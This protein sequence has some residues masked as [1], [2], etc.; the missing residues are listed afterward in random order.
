MALNLPAVGAQDYEDLLFGI[1][2]QIDFI[3]ASFV[4]SADDIM[5]IRQI[6]EE[7][8]ADIHIIAKIENGQ[9]VEQGHLPQLAR[10]TQ[11]PFSPFRFMRETL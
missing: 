9:G 6:L 7:H 10:S 4:R 2:Q 1:A 11:R 5:Q 3:A 8:D